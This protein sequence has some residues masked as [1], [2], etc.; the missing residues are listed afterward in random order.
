LELV[1]P[2]A[3]GSLNNV[4]APDVQV[5]ING[6]A[7]SVGTYSF[8][9]P[10]GSTG[11][12]LDNGLIRFRFNGKTPTSTQ[13]LA[14]SVIVN[15][16]ELAPLDGQNSFYVD[17]AGNGSLVTSQVSVVRNTPDLVE[18]AFVEARVRPRTSLKTRSLSRSRTS[19]RRRRISRSPML[20]LPRTNRPARVLAALAHPILMAEA[21]LL[22]NW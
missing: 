13:M 14:L 9:F 6:V 21:P 16:Q 8:P 15:S 19:T 18:V 12:V 5:F 17:A 4:A 7:A 2:G 20:R 3:L 1:N 11:L 22:I 10:P